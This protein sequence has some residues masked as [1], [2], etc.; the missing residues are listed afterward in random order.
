MNSPITITLLALLLALRELKTPLTQEELAGLADVGQQ[1]ALDPD[2]WEYIAEGLMVIIQGN[3]ELNE[4]FQMA[5]ACLE[6]IDGQIPS[7]V[8]PT[9]TE[10]DQELPPISKGPQDFG[11]KPGSDESDEVLT[12]TIKA[13]E[14]HRPIQAANQLSFLERTSDFL[15]SSQSSRE[16][17]K[18]SEY[19]SESRY[20]NTFFCDLDD[21]SAIP[22]NQ[23]LIA[24]QA[25]TLY[26]DI[27]PEPKGADDT[28]VPF[29][30]QALAQVWDDLESLALDVVVSS[31]DFTIES[32]VKKLILPHRGTSEGVC[33]TVTPTLSTGRGYLQV[34]LF[35][36]GYLLQ[37]KQVEAVIIPQA[38]AQITASSMRPVHTARIT[39]TTTDQLTPEQLKLTPERVLTIDVE[40]DQR[41]G[42][43][44]FRFLDRTDG[45]QEL[46]FYDTVLQPA[47]LGKA[48]AGVRKQLNL[49]AREG[50]QWI[51]QGDLDLL[52]TWLPRFA[53]AGRYLYRA[54]LPQNQGNPTDI[55]QG[56]KLQAALEPGI[57]IQVNPIVGQVTVPWALL[58]ER[59][60]KYQPGK[61]HVCQHCLNSKED[62]PSCPHGDDPY[63]V[64]PYGFWGYRYAIEQ[65]PC[66]VTGELPK[67]TVLVK[68]IANHQPLLLNLNVW[69]E[70]SLW[71]DHLPKLAAAGEVQML[72]AEDITKLEEIWRDHATLDLVYFYCHGG[73]DE[74]LEQPYLEISDGRI[75]SNFLEASNLQWLHNPL[76][77]LNGCATGDY[78]P[79]SYMSLIDDFRVAGACGVIGTECP[80][81]EM[82]AEPY[83]AALLPRLFRGEPLGQAMLTVRRELLREK[84]NPLGLVYS[85]YAPHE[86]VLSRAVAT[87][88]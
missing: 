61:T 20:F 21:S 39:F 32:P 74:I 80:V 70:F 51:D 27:S 44:D 31:H 29:P 60:V 83:G 50:Y 33:F 64:C 30:E 82:F 38:E 45:N 48:I 52:N 47:M 73:I 28:N 49:A 24:Q 76:V 59:E 36:R 78:S 58:Y 75:D 71:R 15:Q 88:N 81:P 79:E 1:L 22:L 14:T 69:K 63:I 87:M 72:V 57:T 55:D 17:Y 42:S 85:L 9:Y 19:P 41:D 46:A 3:E 12:A 68:T 8:L 62:C 34:E 5:K 7:V 77:F 53:H 84:L 2:D 86:V 35:Y 6:A 40:R 11:W 26:L 18:T 65:L 10:L 16:S 13:L 4:Y 67:P 54:I 37:A 66:W 56:E 43:I 25:Y 23:P